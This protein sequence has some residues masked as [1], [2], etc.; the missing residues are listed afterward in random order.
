[1]SI[2]TAPDNGLN[3]FSQAAAVTTG[4]DGGWTAT[5]P[6]GPSRTIRAYYAGSPTILPATGQATV[7][8]PARIAL[9]ITPAAVRWSGAVSISGQLEG[10]YVPPDGVALELMVRYPGSVRPTPLQ[11]MRTNASGGF[12]FRWSYGAGRGVVTY[13]LWVET[14]AT[15]SDF[16]FTNAQS[17]HIMITFGRQ[18]APAAKAQTEATKARKVGRHHRELRRVNGR[19]HH[20][21]HRRRGRHHRREHP[22]RASGSRNHGR[23]GGAPLV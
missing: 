12:A 5:L 1:V 15:E 14:T 13:P 8:V 16:P 4:P 2:L 19:D 18:A 11:P 10:G 22:R 7:T 6:A 17:R 23:S 21:R 20:A 9:S 3:A